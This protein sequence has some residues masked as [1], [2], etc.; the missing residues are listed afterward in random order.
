MTRWIAATERDAT[1]GTLEN[2]LWSAA[3][4][5]RALVGQ[6][7]QPVLGLMRFADAKYAARKAELEKATPGR[8]GARTENASA[9]TRRVCLSSLSLYARGVQGEGG[10]AALPRL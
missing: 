2:R 5:L 8:R 9:I 7:S 3:D 6:Y 10:R 4:E 1:T